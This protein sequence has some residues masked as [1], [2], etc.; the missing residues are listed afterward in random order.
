MNNNEPVI[1][2]AVRI[3]QGGHFLSDVVASAFITIGISVALY[4]RMIRREKAA[5]PKNNPQNPS[6]SP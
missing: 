1:V 6:D 2:G 4:N 3:M 5:S